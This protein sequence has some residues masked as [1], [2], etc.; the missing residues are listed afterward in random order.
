MYTASIIKYR[1]SLLNISSIQLKKKETNITG[2]IDIVGVFLYYKYQ[3]SSYLLFQ[4]T[5]NNKM[6]VDYQT[7]LKRKVK[8]DHECV[9]L[10]SRV[11]KI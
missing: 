5:L 6:Y 11:C 9:S 2:C 1:K 3:P 10:E 4:P 8:S 7:N